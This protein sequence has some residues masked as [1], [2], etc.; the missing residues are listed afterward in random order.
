MFEII[1]V[2]GIETVNGKR[3]QHYFRNWLDGINAGTKAGY[4]K[5]YICRCASLEQLEESIRSGVKNINGKFVFIGH[6]LKMIEEKQLFSV[7][8]A[9]HFD[10]Y[11]KDIY[12]Y[13]YVRFGLKKTN[14]YNLIKVSTEFAHLGELDKRWKE[15]S[16]SQLCEMLSMSEEERQKV[17]P[18]MTIKQIR[19]L[20]NVSELESQQIQTSEYDIEDDTNELSDAPIKLSKN[21]IIDKLVEMLFDGYS[22]FLDGSI[23]NFDHLLD[24]L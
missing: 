6:L 5:D 1:P 14:T 9:Q 21:E 22:R 7:V 3:D 2:V 12:R 13:A 11:C 17:T 20:K 23:K 8:H 16:F 24:G 4:N 18:N 19:E 15:Y 10:D